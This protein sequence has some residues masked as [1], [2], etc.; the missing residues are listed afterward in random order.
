MCRSLCIPEE[1]WNSRGSE[2]MSHPLAK[3]REKGGAIANVFYRTLVSFAL[4]GLVCVSRGPGAYESCY[5]TQSSLW[6]LHF[7]SRF[8]S[9]ESAG[10]FSFAP[11]GLGCLPVH[12]TAL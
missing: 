3:L 2:S 9:A 6:D 5:G 1:P 10:L 11:P 8:P 12:S 7:F 4:S